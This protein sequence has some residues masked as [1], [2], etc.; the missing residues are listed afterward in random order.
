MAP[1]LVEALQSAD[2][3]LGCVAWLTEPRVLEALSGLAGVSLVVQKEDFLRPECLNKAELRA[4]YQRLHGISRHAAPGLASSLSVGGEPELDAVR[5]VGVRPERSKTT[6]KMH[7]KFGVLCRRS[8]GPMPCQW[9]WKGWRPAGVLP[10]CACSSGGDC[11]TWPEPYAVWT[12]SFNWTFNATRSLEN[13]IVLTDPTI[14]QAYV[15]EWAHV[16]SLSEP[17]DWSSEYVY[18]EWRIGT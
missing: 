2:V 14:V 8:P 9:W 7:H 11:T 6:P 17:L 15:N 1:A 12:G 4:A 5:C 13:A 18:P 16:V 3:V 10:D